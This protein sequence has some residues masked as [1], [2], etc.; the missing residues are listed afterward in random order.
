MP[1]R[2]T[3]RFPLPPEYANTDL[4]DALAKVL[5]SIDDAAVSAF[6]DSSQSIVSYLVVVTHDT[7]SRAARR[8]KSSGVTTVPTGSLDS[9]TTIIS[10]ISVVTSSAPVATTLQFDWVRGHLKQ[11]LLWESLVSHVE[12][13][14]KTA[15][16]TEPGNA[17]GPDADM[18]DLATK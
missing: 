11:R 3:L 14:V 9:G 17:R 18:M 13:K 2:N 4:R 8:K 7:W 5:A 15:V 6:D 1:A 10:K 16:A 12:R